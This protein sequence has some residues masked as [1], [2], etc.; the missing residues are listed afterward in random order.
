MVQRSLQLSMAQRS[1]IVQLRRLFLSKI[2]NISQRRR[3]I[4]QTLLV[5]PG[6]KFKT[7]GTLEP[8]P[9]STRGSW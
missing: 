8:N 5:S 9:R 4:H 6:S 3:E 7:A 2:N 1:E